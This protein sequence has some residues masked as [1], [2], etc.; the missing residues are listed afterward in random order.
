MN[1]NIGVI[2]CGKI[3]QI[4]HVPEY[5]ANPNVT[6]KGFYDFPH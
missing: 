3:A 1:I 4:R 2:G 6:I 5:E